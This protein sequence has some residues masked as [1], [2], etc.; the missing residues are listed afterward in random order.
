VRLHLLGEGDPCGGIGVRGS[1]PAG[2]LSKQHRAGLAA[3]TLAARVAAST[4]ADVVSCVSAAL[5][6]MAGSLHG[7]ASR[8]ARALLDDVAE[9]GAVR[10]VTAHLTRS[11]RLPGFGHVLYPDVDPRARV[12]LDLLAEVRTAR[13]T[14]RLV[15]DLAAEAVARGAG[16]P[17]VDVVL[18]A[19]GH[20]TGMAPDAAEP[21]F[22]V[23]RTAGWIAH[24]LEEQ[25][26]RPLRFCARAQ[27][28]GPN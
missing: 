21:I 14:L 19:L 20:A 26:E 3:S 13:R 18:A 5:G 2:H 15:D 1:E 16:H 22:V 4:R 8:R 9:R 12:L 17:N 23:A 24:A 7:T 6:P 11:G 25:G 10:T 27:Y 28:I